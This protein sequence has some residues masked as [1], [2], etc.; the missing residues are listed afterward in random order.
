MLAA[1][2]KNKTV[3]VCCCEFL[4]RYFNMFVNF[5][6]IFFLAS[7]VGCFLRMLDKQ[8]LL[9]KKKLRKMG[10]FWSGD[11]VFIW[12]ILSRLCR[13]L[14]LNKGDRSCLVGAGWKTSW[15]YIN[16]IRNLWRNDCNCMISSF[17]PSRLLSQGWSVSRNHSYLDVSNHEG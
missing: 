13:N 10:R 14:T 3:S 4:Y 11:E 5:G 7:L 15:L 8:A 1:V 16:I 17:V 9:L 2:S 6:T 12:N